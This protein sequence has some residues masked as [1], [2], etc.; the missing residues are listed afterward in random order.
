MVRQAHLGRG[1]LVVILCALLSWV[2]TVSGPAGGP[3]TVL[4]ESTTQPALPD[5]GADQQLVTRQMAAMSLHEKV[6]QLFMVSFAGSA[7]SPYETTLLAQSEPGAVILFA[8]NVGSPN[9]VQLLT[10]SLQDTALHSSGIPLVIAT[11]QEGGTINRITQGV[12]L[13]PASAYWGTV[14]SG[15]AGDVR[16]SARTTAIGL[17][18]LGINMDLAPVV[19]VLTNPCNTVIG[20]RSFGADPAVVSTLGAAEIDGLHDGGLLATAKHFPGYDDTCTDSQVALP[21]LRSTPGK[22]DA[23]DLPPFV[24]AIQHGVDSIMVGHLVDRDL[25]PAG[26]PASLSAPIIQRTLRGRLGFNGVI[27][28]DDLAMGAISGMYSLPQ[29]AV[30]ALQAGADMVLLTN[31]LSESIPAMAAVEDAVN[32]GDLPM[33]RVDDA[34]RR[35]LLMKQH[36]GLFDNARNG[37]LTHALV[38]KPVPS[39]P[40]AVSGA[41]PSIGYI[42]WTLPAA[43][44]AHTA[45]FSL[46]SWYYRGSQAV[47]VADMPHLDPIANHSVTIAAPIGG[48]TYFAQL[49]AYNDTGVASPSSPA[50][51]V[52]ALFPAPAKPSNLHATLSGPLAAQWHWSPD[53]QHTTLYRVTLFHYHGAK[54][55]VDRVAT[56]Q[57]TSWNTAHLPNGDPLGTTYT[58]RVVALNPDGL[59]SQPAWLAARI[60]PRPLPISVPGQVKYTGHT[61]T[62]IT[63]HWQGQHNAFSY[64]VRLV[65]TEHQHV[66]VDTMLRLGRNQ[67]SART[68]QLWPGTGYTLTVWAVNN[69]GTWSLPAMA[70]ASTL[71]MPAVPARD[72]RSPHPLRLIRH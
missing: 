33:A 1:L 35:I 56:L 7:L 70:G 18:A 68:P 39:A 63:W 40:Q 59:E 24:T 38:P 46:E 58:L 51:A 45:Y 25:D 16:A 22:L 55:I 26:T 9:D 32:R 11:D 13:A 65:H 48:I 17:R 72:P 61:Q 57:Q 23:V 50:A 37:I 29:A 67:T 3:R 2:H 69:N 64:R 28:T 42:T 41:A 53:H 52:R 60:Q 66:I 54:P 21:V 10:A 14:G 8:S 43:P 47:I 6:G 15:A 4:A 44:P 19:D 34:V 36:A 62:A 20:S 31:A 12:A 71:P 49:R 30:R 27:L 5:T